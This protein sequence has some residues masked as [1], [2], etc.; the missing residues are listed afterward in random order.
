[1]PSLTDA[2][3]GSPKSIATFARL[4]MVSIG[5]HVPPAFNYNA[6]R[7]LILVEDDRVSVDSEDPLALALVTACDSMVH[8]EVVGQIE[9]EVHASGSLAVL[10]DNTPFARSLKPKCHLCYDLRK[11]GAPI[12]GLATVCDFY[13]D[14]AL[15]TAKLSTQ[16]CRDKSLPNFKDWLLVDVVVSKKKLTGS[17][18]LLQI[19]A[20]ACRSKRSGV[21][22][23]AVTKKGRALFESLGFSTFPYREGGLSK[24]L[25]YARANSLSI[26]TI[27]RRLSFDGDRRLLGD[28]CFRFG[29]T[30]KSS[31]SLIARC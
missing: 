7:R 21:C 30:P 29:L 4:A 13:T 22:A 1:M 15:S 23:I 5:T 17:L 18:L 20:A 8:V 28:L 31:S 9:V 14:D 26:D 6:I 25:V 16:F 27:V 12:C 24:V 19:Y 10:F 3:Y 11:P 2:G